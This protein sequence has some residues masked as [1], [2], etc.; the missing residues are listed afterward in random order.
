MSFV[1]IAIRGTPSGEFVSHWIFL[2]FIELSLPHWI[3]F[4]RS[5]DDLADPRLDDSPI[6]SIRV[7]LE[8]LRSS[9]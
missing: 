3:G 4:T 2:I 1:E 9:V 5:E 8:T 7:Y 6:D